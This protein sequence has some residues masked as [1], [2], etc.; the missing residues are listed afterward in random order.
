MAR[1]FHCE[2]FAPHPEMDRGDC[3]IITKDEYHRKIRVPYIV[4]DDSDPFLMVPMNFGCALFEPA[5]PERD[6]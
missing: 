5:T 1:C 2:H 6:D 4:S 3:K